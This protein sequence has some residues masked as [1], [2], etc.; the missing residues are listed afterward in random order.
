[1][2]TDRIERDIVIAASPRRVWDI[3]TRA[4]HLGTWFADVSAEID[5]RPGGALTLTWARYGTSHGIVETVEPYTTFAFRWAVDDRTPGDGNAT[6]VAFTL[7]PDGDGTRLRVV[8]SGFTDLA[9]GAETQ[10]THVEQNT[11]GWRIELD[12]L[13]VYAEF[14]AT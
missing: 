9:G 12:E 11:E 5:L 2:T 3:V 14:G 13:R 10:A 1:M 6:L 8:E 7:T 4:E